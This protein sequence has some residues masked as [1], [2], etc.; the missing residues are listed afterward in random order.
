MGE[1]RNRRWKRWIRAALVMVTLS[2]WL[3]QVGR[4]TADAV[5]SDWLTVLAVGS[6]TLVSV[7]KD[8]FTLL[9]Q[10][11]FSP[12]TAGGL[13]V[14]M[15]MIQGDHWITL[16]QETVGTLGISS[17]QISNAMRSFPRT[18][19]YVFAQ[20]SPANATGRITVEKV[21]KLPNGVLQ[22]YQ[23]N[24]TPWSGEW[25]KAQGKFRT[26][27]EV[28]SNAIGYN[29]FEAFKGAQTDPLFHN[30]AWSGMLVA[31]GLAMRHYRANVAYIAAAHPIVTPLIITSGGLLTTTT[32]T[33]LQG[34]V[35]PRWY[36]AT[37]MAA[38]GVLPGMDASF[39]VRNLTSCDAPEHVVDAGISASPWKGGN[40]P[41]TQDLIYSY[42]TSQT[43]W[44]VL[45][46]TILI[47]VFT[48]GFGDILIPA[49]YAT[50]NTVLG[51]GGPVTQGKNGM[52]GSVETGS[53][54]AQAA[55]GPVQAQMMQNVETRFMA[56]PMGQGGTITA[57]DALYDGSH[58]ANPCQD[59]L[60]VAQCLSQ[61]LDPGTIWR[62]DSYV[63]YNNTAEMRQRY[64]NCVQQGLSGAAA[65][66]CAAPQTQAIV[67]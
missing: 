65:R 63:E 4:A 66:Q 13:S 20:Y 67:P 25:W 50:L 35:Y 42:Q 40:M 52:F 27:S 24:F 41:S 18:S 28:A 5:A 12:G 46:F 23:S 31:V 36:V 44:T 60:T 17:Q 56:N 26:P 33:T 61:G 48:A 62:P 49:A 45:A 7:P 32:T 21:E 8:D 51:P 3:L 57:T 22:V 9:G 64:N 19:A 38:V 54:A 29:P 39:C 58:T 15:Q 6:G 55:S 10:G 37:P 1:M 43:S 53:T 16:G 34:Y 47:T 2:L 14:V 59:G 30:V 11:S